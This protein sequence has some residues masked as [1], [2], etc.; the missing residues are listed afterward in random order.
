M[1]YKKL[2]ARLFIIVGA[3]ALWGFTRIDDD[4]IAKIA[5]QLEEWLSNHPQ[6]KVYLQFDKP[7]YAIGDTIWFKAYDLIA[8]R[9]QLSALSGVLNVD[10]IDDRD[11]VKKSIKLPI[12]NGV[13]WGDFVLP[14]SLTEGNYRVRAYTNWMRN[15]GEDYFFDKSI[16]VNAITNTV[17][18]KTNYSY[19][20]QNGQQKINSVINYTD[21]DGK[22][23]AGKQVN[24][25]VMTGKKTIDRGKGQTDENGNLNISFANAAQVTLKPRRIITTL[26]VNDKESVTKSIVIKATS[27]KVDVQF[28][29]EGGPLVVGNPSKIAFKA[30]GSDGLGATIKGVVID[31]QNNQV[32][33]I[34]TTHLGMG[35]FNLT[36]E[37]NKTYKAK[38][39]YTDGSENT[40][41]LPKATDQGYSL[42]VSNAGPSHFS[43]R[44]LPGPA[45]STAVQNGLMSIIAQ[46]NG[47]ICYAG[48]SEAGKPFMAHILKSKFPSGI[49]QF[50]L[51]SS[52]GEPLN[53]RVVF[54]KN[55]DQLK[56]NVTTGKESYSARQKIKI[57]VNAKD[58]ED[59]PVTGSFSVSV[60]NETNVPVDEISESTIL[61]NLLLTSDIKGYVEKPNYYFTNT[62][63]T[64]QADLDVL[65]LTQGYRR[66]E[67]KQLLNNSIPPDAYPAEKSLSLAGHIKTLGGKPLP[68][69][70]VKILSNKG[71]FFFRDTV[72]DNTGAFSFNGLVFKDSTKFLIQAR[73]AKDRKNVQIDLDNTAPQ[74]VGV[75]KNAADMQVNIN[76]GLSQY[77]QSSKALYDSELK[78]GSVK[79]PIILKGVVV[80]AKKN[81]VVYSENLNGPGNAD[82]VITADRLGNCGGFLSNC[83]QGLIAGVTF[84]NNIPFNNRANAAMAIVLDGNFIDNDLFSDINPS[85]VQSVEVL[86]GPFRTAIYGSRGAN[87]ILL[88]TSKK[89]RDAM[90]AYER[91]APGVITYTPKGYYKVRDFYS[92]QHNNPKTDQQLPDLR[93]TIY[94]NPNFITDKAGKASFQFFNADTKGTYRVVIEGVDS[95]GNL[96]R[97]VFRYKV[98]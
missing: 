78:A 43:L 73:S 16:T 45:A 4:P 14:D 24:Y 9:H 53:E 49:V 91:Y 50:T 64:T 31:D 81:K 36:P 7:Y 98:E 83:L 96:G 44:V 17:F 25:E 52:T 76:D 90:S 19:N 41:E 38:L 47:V 71:G 66:F 18:T 28:F 21:I 87:G 92:P 97:Q 11:S 94:W 62:N 46:V 85:N 65:M 86:L 54:V 26:K 20:T 22:P 8:R 27:E 15:A 3:T 1:N 5:A 72:A 29:P 80:N 69:G 68:N 2:L 51:F 67:W 75:N 56:L 84:R 61:S 35:V 88:I 13:S 10:L 32:A 23:Y 82:A 33:E 42:I 60:T 55:P 74:T 63:E 37:S 39:T 89:G 12:E 40:V 6:E 77:L 57:E 93:S 34:A 48:K 95:D 70:A 59:K 30:I 79:R 58:K